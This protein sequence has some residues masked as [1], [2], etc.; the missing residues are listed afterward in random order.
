MCF[1]QD[2]I[3]IVNK[4]DVYICD[5]G[6]ITSEKGSSLGKVRPCVIISSN[7]F[8]TPFSNQYIIAPMRS[9]S[10]SGVTRENL[11]EFISERRKVGRVYI[12]VSYSNGDI[13]FID[14]TQ[15]R[16]IDSQKLQRYIGTIGNMELRRKINASVMEVLFSRDEF[17]NTYESTEIET[18]EVK[19]IEE[20]KEEEEEKP[21][22]EKTKRKHTGG[23]P[24]KK[25]P[26]GFSLHY[27][28]LKAGRTTYADLANKCG[29][30]VATLRKRVKEFEADHPEL[31]AS[32]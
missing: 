20:I 16:Q 22:E 10:N 18:V 23:K 25:L 7:D 11:Q 12:P 13:S 15:M 29:M 30:S 4:F 24:E 28:M 5:L 2:I 19:T 9:E 1:E 8:N 26:N 3:R 17:T 14:I 27:K 31:V 6:E 32:M 21:I